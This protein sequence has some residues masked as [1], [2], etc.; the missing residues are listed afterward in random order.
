M[1]VSLLHHTACPYLHQDNVEQRAI[2]TIFGRGTEWIREPVSAAV[3][4]LVS[5]VH[6]AQAVEDWKTAN[7]A[8]QEIGRVAKFSIAEERE[9]VLIRGS[10]WPGVE[11]HAPLHR[12]PA[13][14]EGSGDWRLVVKVDAGA[15]LLRRPVMPPPIEEHGHG[16]CKDERCCPPHTT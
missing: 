5:V 13:I 16:S 3:Q 6:D 14:A 1:T 2:C 7:A 11:R 8:K 9:V 12:S 10:K 4:S 15:T